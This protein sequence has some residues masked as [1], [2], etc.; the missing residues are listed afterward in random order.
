VQHCALDNLGK[1]LQKFTLFLAEMQTATKIEHS[2]IA[3]L[4]MPEDVA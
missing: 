3:E 4:R 2:K 1:L